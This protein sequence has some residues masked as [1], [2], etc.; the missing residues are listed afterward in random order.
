MSQP[1]EDADRGTG[2]EVR[3]DRT[4]GDRDL[5]CWRSPLGRWS[6]RIMHRIS[7][8]LGPKKALVLI[9]AL[10]AAIS[11]TMTWVASEIYEAVIE[12][13]GVALLDHPVLE[14]M[15]RLRSPWLD[16]FATDYTNLGGVIGMPILATVIMVILALRRRSWTPVILITAAGVGSLLMTIAGKELTGRARPALVDAVPPYEYSPSFPSGHTLNSLVI[17]GVVAYLLV[18]RQR[19][20]RDRVL[21]VGVAALFAFTIG[22]SRVFLGHHWLTD[23]LAAWFL[24][25]AWLSVVIMTH[26]LYLSATRRITEGPVDTELPGGG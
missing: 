6:A 24:G 19:R 23:V 20:R 26:R 9:L 7:L 5:T 11:A 14:A 16:A 8:T 21:T 22:V 25:V 12:T 4:V 17:A 3:E 10:G 18:L 15:K 2:G 1:G 13:D